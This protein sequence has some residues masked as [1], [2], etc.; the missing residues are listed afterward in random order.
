[1]RTRSRSE[2]PPLGS[3]SGD[4]L[5]AHLRV[6]GLQLAGHVEQKVLVVDDLQ[7]PDVGLGLQVGRGHLRIHGYQ[8]KHR[9][10]SASEP[11]ETDR[12]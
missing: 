11:A 5:L 8:N 3:G 7:L 1:M 4:P 12:W 2:R 9:P 6:F 10:V